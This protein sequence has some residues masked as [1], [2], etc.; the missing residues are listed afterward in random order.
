M[1]NNPLE[2]P[3]LQAMRASMRPSGGSMRWS[4]IL[5]AVLVVA[6]LTF[7]FAFYLPLLR[8]HETLTKHFSE[9]QTR[10]DSAN[11]SASEARADVKELQEKQQELEAKLKQAEEAKQ[12]SAGAGSSSSSKGALEAKLQKPLAKDQAALG[13][14]EGQAIAGLSLGYALTKG[15]LAVSPDGQAALCGVAGTS[16]KRPIRVL[17]IAD[18]K[19]IPPALAAK[20]KTPLDYSG[21]VAALV[22]ETLRDKCKVDP[23]YLS[24]TGFPAE[25]AAPQVEGKRLSGARVELWL[26]N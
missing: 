23:T 14:A 3:D 21:A 11:K 15:K 26:A 6:C 19:S 8:A 5:T 17:A 22:V 13:S 7:A 20:L 24:A 18:K 25:P 1:G 12:P 9:V 10:V 2:D 16:S 4:R